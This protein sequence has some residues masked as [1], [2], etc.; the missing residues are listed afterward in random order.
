MAGS[1]GRDTTVLV[2]RALIGG[3]LLAVL[4]L[5]PTVAVSVSQGAPAQAQRMKAFEVVDNLICIKPPAT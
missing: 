1:E 4:T 2:A 3:C 5:R